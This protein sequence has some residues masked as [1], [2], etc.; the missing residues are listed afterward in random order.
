MRIASGTPLAMRAG[1]SR[2]VMEVHGMLTHPNEE[3]T[4]NTA[5]MMGDRDDGPVGGV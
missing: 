4:R 2:D 5:E 3:I 1:V